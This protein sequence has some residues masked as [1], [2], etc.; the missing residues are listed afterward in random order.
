MRTGFETRLA[1]R[2]GAIGGTT[3]GLAPGYVQGNLAV[4]PKELAA[5]F[6][7]FCQQNPKPC[8]LIAVSDSGDPRIPALSTDLDIRTDI[9]SYCVWKDG[10]IIDEPADVLKWWRDDLVAF[11]IGCSYSFEEG[12]IQWHRRG[13]SSILD[14][15][16]DLFPPFLQRGLGGGRPL[17]VILPFDERCCWRA[18]FR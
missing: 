17:L 14:C 5:D 15:Q 4:L 18:G 9:P 16:L 11:V 2:S 7:R 6:L 3:A 10:K 13:N 12:S 8:P 1:C